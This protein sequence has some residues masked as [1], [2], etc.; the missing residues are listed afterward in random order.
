[1]GPEEPKDKNI[2]ARATVQLTVEVEVE[3]RWSGDT[4]VAQVF[5]Q[6]ERS[7]VQLLAAAL[8]DQV[9]GKLRVLN[10]KVTGVFSNKA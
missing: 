4:T 9:S 7:A 1:M 5:R 2:G 8:N 6:A 10:A 3:D